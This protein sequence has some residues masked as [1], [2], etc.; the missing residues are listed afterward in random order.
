MGRS[1]ERGGRTA[2]PSVPKPGVYPIDSGTAELVQDRD[3][4][5]GYL[6]LING[7]QSSHIDL[8]DPTWLDF[9][10]MRW[11][12][13]VIGSALPDPLRV[14]HLGAAACSLARHLIDGHPGSQHLAVDTDAE[15]SRLVRVWFDLPRAPALRIRV[16]DAREVTE[17]LADDSYSVVVRDVFADAV[18]PLPLTTAEFTAQVRRVLRP[19]G[20]YLLNCGD[21]PDLQLSRS[22]AATVGSVF[23]HVGI[24]ADPPMLKGRRRGNV[25]VIGSDASIESAALARELLSGAVPAQLWEDRRVRE[26]AKGAPVLVDAALSG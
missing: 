9:E 22:E 14:L 25:I 1:R 23:E 5:L 7:V 3:N 6:L 15:L 26:F 11:I 18:T 10:Y 21:R 4:P 24:V 20:L 19:G 8:G 13:A 12:A 16:G 17:S 2:K